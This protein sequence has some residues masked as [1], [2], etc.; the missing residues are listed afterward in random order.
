MGFTGEVRYVAILI[1]D[2]QGKNLLMQIFSRYATFL[3]LVISFLFSSSVFAQKKDGVRSFRS[4]LGIVFLGGS[5][6]MVKQGIDFRN[7]ADDLYSRY[8][9]S[10]IADE[11]DRLYSRT[12]NRD[13]KSQVSLAIAGAFAISGVRFLFF[14]EDGEADE[15]TDAKKREF[16]DTSTGNNVFIKPALKI[17]GFGVSLSRKFF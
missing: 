7:E 1:Y 9:A 17:G 12:N 14:A 3:F 10:R 16:L 4:S 6:F 13:I 5:A 2:F 15:D 11:A 8:Q